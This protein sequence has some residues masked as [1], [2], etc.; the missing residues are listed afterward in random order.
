MRAAKRVVT[1]GAAGV[2]RIDLH[3]S[4]PQC[5]DGHRAG[6]LTKATLTGNRL[7]RY[8]NKGAIFLEATE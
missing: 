2:D 4:R 7:H 1:V 3:T 6:I 8:M 5:L